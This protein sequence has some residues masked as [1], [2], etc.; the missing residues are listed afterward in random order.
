MDVHGLILQRGKDFEILLARWCSNQPYNILH[1]SVVMRIK[2]LS[3][4]FT[5]SQSVTRKWNMLSIMCK[6]M[7]SCKQGNNNCGFFR[8]LYMLQRRMRLEFVSLVSNHNN[9]KIDKYSSCK[10][11]SLLST[12][13]FFFF[14]F[15]FNRSRD[16]QERDWTYVNI[17]PNWSNKNNG[18]WLRKWLNLSSKTWAR[19][20][21]KLE[22]RT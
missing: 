4:G 14:P 6:E 15:S 16:P 13:S 8:K 2:F 20:F 17:L 11:L 10:M 22:A 12:Y 18:E 19:R 3:A 21:T 9:K 5:T 1:I 7:A